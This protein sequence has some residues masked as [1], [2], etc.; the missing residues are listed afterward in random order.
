[1]AGFD[2]LKS[3]SEPDLSCPGLGTNPDL[4]SEQTTSESVYSES[5]KMD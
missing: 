3:I 1:M 2:P 4:V 5:V